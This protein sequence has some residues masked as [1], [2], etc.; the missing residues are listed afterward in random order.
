[1]NIFTQQSVHSLR[2]LFLEHNRKVILKQQRRNSMQFYLHIAEEM[3]VL[4]CGCFIFGAVHP[5]MKHH[6]QQFI[7]YL[8]IL[9]LTCM[10]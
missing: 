5:Q 10:V 6:V 1:M 9:S 3:K 7:L 4:L 8:S 2:V